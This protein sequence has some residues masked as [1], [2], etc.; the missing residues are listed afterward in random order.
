[1]HVEGKEGYDGGPHEGPHGRQENNGIADRDRHR[2]RCLRDGGGQR[3][4]HV[5]KIA[6]DHNNRRWSPAGLV[7]LVCVCFCC[8]H[9]KGG[10]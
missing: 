2:S 7:L 4:A 9:E 1:M 3:R 6:I 8:D 5:V 10:I